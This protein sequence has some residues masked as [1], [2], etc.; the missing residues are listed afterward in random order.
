MKRST[1]VPRRAKTAPEFFSD[2]VAR[3]RRFYLSLNPPKDCRL[4]VVCGGLESTT[5]EYAIKRDSF[6]FYSIEYVVGGRGKVK[7]NGRGGSLEA[8]R[9]FSYGPEV[10]QEISGDPAEPLVKYFV[11]FAG[12]EAL[13]LLRSCHLAPGSMMQIYPANALQPL[14]D[15][16]IQTGLRAHRSSAAFCAKILECLTLKINIAKTPLEDM[17]TLAFRTHEE[18][19][20]HIE[21]NFCRLRNLGQISKE[22]HVTNGYLCRLFS[23]YEQQ[24]PYTYLLRLKMNYAAELLQKGNILVKQVAE[25]VGF[26]N[27][28]LFSRRFKYVF[29]VSPKAFRGFKQKEQQV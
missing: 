25:Q 11:D 26:E 7:L 16:L 4:A 29:G 8:G 14:F 28:F 27:E 1:R 22:C 23:R 10:R 17:N 9:I 21:K 12:S 13:E 18:C 2:K 5:P 15:E 3:A 6:P 24:S 20:R 19:R